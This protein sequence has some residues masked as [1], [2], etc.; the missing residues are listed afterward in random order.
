MSSDN[1][2]N[3]AAPTPVNGTLPSMMP[4]ESIIVGNGPECVC[5]TIKILTR[6]DDNKE[7]I[8]YLEK[9]IESYKN[10]RPCVRIEVEGKPFGSLEND[11]I[12][13]AMVRSIQRVK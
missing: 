12:Q 9:Y 11:M 7:F 4:S 3:S 5:E 13:M 2:T 6:E 8:N 1:A 10:E